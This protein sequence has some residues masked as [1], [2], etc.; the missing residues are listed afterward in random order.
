MILL[1]ILWGLLAADT[2]AEKQECQPVEAALASCQMCVIV[3]SLDRF[4]SKTE[5]T[6]FLRNSL[7][8]TITG[9]FKVLFWKLPMIKL[10]LP[11][12]AAQPFG[13]SPGLCHSVLPRGWIIKSEMDTEYPFL[14][15]LHPF[16]FLGF[17]K[18]LHYIPKEKVC[19]KPG[20]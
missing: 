9:V 15:N 19:Q 6:C 4:G 13:K 11:E 1:L 16:M 2:S 20:R 17:L 5:L 7:Y 3:A 10:G 12:L 14:F 18:K 8:A